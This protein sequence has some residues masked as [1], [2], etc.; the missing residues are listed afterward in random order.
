MT[1]TSHLHHEHL[2]VSMSIKS[3][4]SIVLVLYDQFN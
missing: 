4:T 2:F 3:I 1:V